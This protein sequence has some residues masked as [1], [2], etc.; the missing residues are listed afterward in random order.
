MTFLNKSKA[1]LDVQDTRMYEKAIRQRW[2]IPD[3]CRL[4]IVERQ[5]R[6]AID[7][8]S[9]E[10]AASIATR[11]L[12]EMERQNQQDEHHEQG[13]TVKV[14]HSL[15]INSIAEQITG[16]E[17]F[18]EYL[19]TRACEGDTDAGTVRQVGL[20]RNTGAVADGEPHGGAGPG[21]NG[22]RNGN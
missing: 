2:P 14:E 15:D 10:R 6:I 19:R 16:E 21:T 18:V 13:E 3:E 12:L 8:N 20:T 22:S 7:P 5:I 17:G 9:S 1:A 4:P 11:C